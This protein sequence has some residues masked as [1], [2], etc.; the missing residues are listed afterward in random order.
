MNGSHEASE[1]LDQEL[2]SVSP[3][4]LVR[5]HHEISPDPG[6]GEA[7]SSSQWEELL[8]IRAIFANNRRDFK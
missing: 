8:S 3:F 2:R 1:G 4:L 6:E 5:T 7:N